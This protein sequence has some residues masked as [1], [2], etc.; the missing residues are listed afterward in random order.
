[1]DRDD[2][3][4][5]GSENV[6]WSSNGTAPPTGTYYVR[7]EPYSTSSTINTIDIITVV[8]RIT[9]LSGIINV[10]TRTFISFLKN[11]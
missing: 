2:Q 3:I 10:F 4:N 9:G 5:E 11:A 7:F 8:Y 1:L 6:Y